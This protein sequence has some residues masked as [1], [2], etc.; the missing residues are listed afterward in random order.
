MIQKE[1]EHIWVSG[2]CTCTCGHVS[3]DIQVDE[4]RTKFYLNVVDE[5]VNALHFA[6]WPARNAELAAPL[7]EHSEA[8]FKLLGGLGDGHR[9]VPREFLQGNLRKSFTATARSNDARLVA[10][11]GLAQTLS[12]ALRTNTATRSSSTVFFPL[13]PPAGLT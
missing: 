11:I 5:T 6:M 2:V 9:E 1:Q 7:L 3:H 8:N 4:M 12:H 10:S 13:P